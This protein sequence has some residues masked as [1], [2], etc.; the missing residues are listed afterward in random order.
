MQHGARLSS[1]LLSSPLLFFPLLSFSF[2]LARLSV[3]YVYVIPLTPFISAA[4]RSKIAEEITRILP[5]SAAATTIAP[6]TVPP[7]P[8]PPPSPRT[9][10]SGA[11]LGAIGASR[12]ATPPLGAA[13]TSKRVSTFVELAVD[14]LRVAQCIVR[15]FQ[16]APDQTRS[17]ANL[18]GRFPQIPADLPKNFGQLILARSAS[19]SASSYAG[20][21]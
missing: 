19:S 2:S 5:R 4:G 20:I 1:P 3:S 15:S 21:V 11:Y 7:P 10:R 12:I 13:S 8:P 6:R 14:Y 16:L 9:P 18:G 17:R